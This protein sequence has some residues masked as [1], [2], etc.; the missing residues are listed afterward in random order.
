MT[1]SNRNSSKPSRPPYDYSIGEQMRRLLRLISSK[2][3]EAMQDQ[4]EFLGT[5]G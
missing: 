1:G 3:A 5:W 4:V 2:S